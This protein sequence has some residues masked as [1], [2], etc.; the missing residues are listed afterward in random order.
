M[1]L[2]D[3]YDQEFNNLSQEI[4]R[5]CAELK[6]CSSS[7]SSSSADNLIRQIDP[8][9]SQASD[10]TKQMNIEARTQ[11]AATRRILSE[12]VT[13]F[14]KTLSSLRSDFERSKEQAQRSQLIG[15]KSAAD[16][17]RLLDTNDKYVLCA[18]L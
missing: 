16:R 17:Q 2:F 7:N 12:K 11:D 3:A 8:L 14:N 13:H 4:Q 5:K 15:A 10:I 18:C 9:F 1:S 6:E